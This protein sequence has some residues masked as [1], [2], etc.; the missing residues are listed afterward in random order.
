MFFVLQSPHC[1]YC[2][3]CSLGVVMSRSNLTASHQ[4]VWSTLPLV[5]PVGLRLRL[6]G[7]WFSTNLFNLFVICF[8]H[9]MSDQ[10]KVQNSH[11]SG[12]PIGSN[13]PAE[14][15][16]KCA[17]CLKYGCRGSGGAPP[18]TE[19]CVCRTPTGECT[20][21]MFIYILICF[22]F[23]SRSAS[24]PDHSWSSRSL[25]SAGA[26]R[27]RSVDPGILSQLNF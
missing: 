19:S 18:C 9:R 23:L 13:P 26:L 7:T 8:S 12:D 1:V 11:S 14:S 27:P 10:D 21:L 22:C 17:P 15:L 4:A 20:H 25:S 5:L 6:R 2:S 24:S 16:P 3:V